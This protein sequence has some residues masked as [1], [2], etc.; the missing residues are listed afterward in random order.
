MSDFKTENA[1]NSI[2]DGAP[3]PSDTTRGA[4]STPETH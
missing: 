3:H 4:Y 2:S 1:L